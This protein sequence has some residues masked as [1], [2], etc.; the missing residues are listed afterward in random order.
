MTLVPTADQLI[1]L[2]ETKDAVM[3]SALPI[4]E[5][6][7]YS[8]CT[9][10]QIGWPHRVTRAIDLIRYAD[11]CNHPGAND[12]FL[13]DAVLPL[14]LPVPQWQRGVASRCSPRYAPVVTS[15][16]KEHSYNFGHGARGDSLKPRFN[17]FSALQGVLQGFC[18][19]DEQREGD[20]SESC[21][22]PSRA[23]AGQTCSLKA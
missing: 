1:E 21:D 18:G 2:Y 16:T 9:F 12:Y 10:D 17:V 3:R 14:S 15:S 6:Q 22:Y 23:S 5:V 20:C 7:A 19:Y 4:S 8:T 13:E 11:W